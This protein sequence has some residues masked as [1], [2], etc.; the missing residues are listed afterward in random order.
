MS[1]IDLD[2][3]EATPL[4]RDPYDH[5][6]VPGFLKSEA[7]AAI[8]ADYPHIEKAGSFPLGGLSYGAAFKALIDELQGPAIRAAFADKF[9]ISLEGRPTM[10][11]VRGV[12]RAKDGKIHNDSATKIIT[13]LIY[14]NT[15]WGNEGGRLRVLRSA[16]TLDDYAAEV[17]P[18]AGTLLAFRR[19]ENSWHG[20]ESFAGPRRA[21]QLNWVTD[22]SVVRR[23]GRRHGISAWIK[24]LFKAD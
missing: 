12:C 6:I 4:E 15:E 22:Q 2:G 21:I 23:E 19:S 13:V 5:L 7:I 24:S 10:L 16:D 14:M 3:F 17:P 20:H 8:D 1:A 18:V 9:G 11:T